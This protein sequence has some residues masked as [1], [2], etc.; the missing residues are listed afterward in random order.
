MYN[1]CNVVLKT[2]T[3]FE[4]LKKSQMKVSES[5]AGS[6]CGLFFHAMP[7]AWVW[8]HLPDCQPH[9]ARRL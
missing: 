8:S 2:N 7:E 9:Q 1:S 5:P 6:V 4:S 3:A